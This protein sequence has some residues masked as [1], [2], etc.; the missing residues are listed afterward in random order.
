[1]FDAQP[2]PAGLRPHQRCWR[3]RELQTAAKTAHS[4]IH[5]VGYADGAVPEPLVLGVH[6]VLLKPSAGRRHICQEK[7]AALEVD[8]DVE[9]QRSNCRICFW[10]STPLALD[11]PKLM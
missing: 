10:E 2:L 3:Y 9:V 8:L 11:V 4:D 1:M 7:S 5:G 6:V